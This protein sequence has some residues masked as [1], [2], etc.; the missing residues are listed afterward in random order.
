[1]KT[2]FAVS[3]SI[4]ILIICQSAFADYGYHYNKRGTGYYRDDSNDGNS[5]NNAN[6]LGMNNRR[7][8]SGSYRNIWDK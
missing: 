2:L 7:S 5:Y 4:L 6:S 1:M 8:G 3:V